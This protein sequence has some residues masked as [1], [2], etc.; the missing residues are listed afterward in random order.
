MR[1]C[2]FL[3]LFFPTAGERHVET[4]QP[5][6]LQCPRPR[7]QALLCGGTSWLRFYRGGVLCVRL[8]CSSFASAEEK[9][10][11]SVSAEGMES[12][13]AR[14]PTRVGE[15]VCRKRVFRSLRRE[16]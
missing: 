5:L 16:A 6:S 13:L 14:R 2:S 4:Y 9:R 15:A 10:E 7:G 12:M 11:C 8:V 1:L 3:Y